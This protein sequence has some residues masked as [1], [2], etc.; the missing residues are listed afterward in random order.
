MRTGTRS[1]RGGAKSKRRQQE[2]EGVSSPTVLHDKGPN[3]KDQQYE[4][5][6]T[7]V[8]GR[9]NSPNKRNSSRHQTPQSQAPPRSWKYH[10][11]TI[12]LI[13]VNDLKSIVAPETA[14]GIF[15]ALAPTLTTHPDPTIFTVFSRLPH[16]ILWNWLNVLLFDIANQRLPNSILE[17]SVNKPWRPIPTGRLTPDEARR[18]LL[19][20]IPVVFGATLWLGGM[21]EAVAM[22]VLT[23]M[24]NDLGAADEV[25]V[26]R[27]IINALGFM[28][29]SSGATAVA[30]GEYELTPRAYTWIAI[31]GAIIFST[32]SM[33]DLP[34]VEG[35]A[36]RGRLTSPLVHGDT[37]ARWSI[38][39]PILFWSFFCPYFWE[40]GW[41]G[42]AIPLV[43]GGWL[44]GRILKFRNVAGDK[45]SWQMWCFWTG[46]LYALPLFAK[47]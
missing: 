1:R 22:M 47:A 14:F 25:Y 10:L 28:C 26:V 23:W 41:M 30:A 15:S 2:P 40:V 45:K 36:A 31:V 12:W 21:W 20:V 9:P 38:A 44:A 7:P 42:Y 5:E 4:A 34:D 17:D 13:T 37:F 32:L 29:Y 24:Y 11:R 27:N 8:T 43:F 35:D 18:L 39:I 33:Q 6:A 46:V 3:A 19:V 16:V